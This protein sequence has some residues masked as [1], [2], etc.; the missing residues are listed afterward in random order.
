MSKRAII[1]AG[2]KG[3]RLLP[4]TSSIPKPMVTINDKPIL[5]II[6]NRLKKYGF[7][8]IIIT[9]NH[10][11]NVISDYFGDGSKFGLKIIYSLENKP[12]STMGP[13]K[14]IENL[15]KNFIIMNGDVL[16]DLDI[17]SFFNSHLNKK[18]IFTISSYSRIQKN[19]FGVLKIDK[20]NYLSEFKEKP[21]YELNVSIGIYAAN[22]K[23]LDYIPNDIPFGF[24]DLM[25]VL[26]NNNEKVYVKKFNGYWLDIGRPDDYIKA[27]EHLKI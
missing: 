12:L 7:K 2:G 1:L 15:P 23:I 20:N 17:S 25:M 21:T 26:L 9:V 4:Y 27:S 24:D 14:L 16:T 3:T 6:L 8:E 19:N 5:E 11:A 10:L 18:N 13:L 22:K